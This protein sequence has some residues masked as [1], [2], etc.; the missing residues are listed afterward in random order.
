MAADMRIAVEGAESLRRRRVLTR[1]LLRIVPVVAGILLIA[2]ILVRWA[3]V[4]A[5]SFWVLLGVS[6]LGVAVFALINS[7]VPPVDDAAAAQ[8]D[9]DA[10]LNGELRSAHWFT[11][12]SDAVKDDWTTF[13]VK[14]AAQRLEGVSWPSVYPP[15]QIARVSAAST[16]M[17]LAAVTLVLTS[18]FA[19]SRVR[20][21]ASAGNTAGNGAV[22]GSALPKDLQKQIDELI[23]AVQRGAIPMD[24]ARAKAAELRDALAKLDPKLQDA[25]AKAAQAQGQKSGDSPNSSKDDAEAAAL[26]AKA[27]KAASEADLPKDMKWSMEDLAAKLA[28]A[29][30]RPSPSDGEKAASGEKQSG[31]PDG[32]QA[33]AGQM[34]EDAGMQVTRTTAT[35]AQ[36]NQMMASTASPMSATARG[37]NAPNDKKAP[38]SGPL[39]LAAL[40]KETVQA[41]MDSQG[42]NVLTELRRKSEQSHSKMQFS[43]VA[44]LATYDKTHAAAP[45]IPPDTLRSLVRQYFIRR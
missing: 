5:S 8:L 9:A 23:N 15:V 33:K 22:A 30:Q 1:Q 39:N 42:S 19:A 44:P 10:Q 4:P 45:P 40:K 2:A 3:H 6:V 32:E 29:S 34:P 21:G 31:K 26:A 12:Q 24:Q 14:G 16:F 11:A 28:K 38:L 13:H 43:R 35:D 37:E 7:R 17:V 41:D 20:A 36:S 18:T 25:L 27:E